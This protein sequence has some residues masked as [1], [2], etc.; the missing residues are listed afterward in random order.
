M[1][2]GRRVVLG[3]LEGDIELVGGELEHFVCA[4]SILTCRCRLGVSQLVG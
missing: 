4:H 3:N 1:K 2:G